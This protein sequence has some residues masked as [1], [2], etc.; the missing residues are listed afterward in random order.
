MQDKAFDQVADR[1]NFNA[2]HYTSHRTRYPEFR[3]RY[4]DPLADASDS[5]FE[6]LILAG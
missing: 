6:N 4:G 3:L 5:Y 2:V 1:E